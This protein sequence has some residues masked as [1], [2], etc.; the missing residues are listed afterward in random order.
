MITKDTP[1]KEAIELVSKIAKEKGLR[2]SNRFELSKAISI[3][4]KSI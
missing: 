4:N 2:T 1:V 3:Y